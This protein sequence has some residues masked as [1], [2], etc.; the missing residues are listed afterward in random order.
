MFHAVC[1]FT[2]WLCASYLSGSEANHSAAVRPASPTITAGTSP[3]Q[4]VFCFIVDLWM[5]VI[6]LCF[7][8]ALWLK[9]GSRGRESA[10]HSSSLCDTM[11]HGAKFG[12]LNLC[13]SKYSSFSDTPV[14]CQLSGFLSIDSKTIL[15]EIFGLGYNAASF[16]SSL[17]L[18]LW[19]Y[20]GTTTLIHLGVGQDL[21]LIIEGPCWTL[22]LAPVWNRHHL[23][24]VYPSDK[25]D[26]DLSASAV[27]TAWAMLFAQFE[28][29]WISFQSLFQAWLLLHCFLTPTI[30]ACSQIPP[31]KTSVSPSVFT[32]H[33]WTGHSQSIYH[34][35]ASQWLRLS[36]APNG[37]TSIRKLEGREIRNAAMLPIICPDPI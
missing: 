11:I 17:I 14:L 4:R 16:F 7:W 31:Q 8:L 3:N 37:H 25:K 32:K 1:V 26:N 22:T 24:I 6:F 2:L 27:F 23:S 10:L 29:V 15:V 36:D 28:K 20:L 18:F 33:G 13:V 35:Q 12:L 30:V 5:K 34:K 21:N 9:E 19:L